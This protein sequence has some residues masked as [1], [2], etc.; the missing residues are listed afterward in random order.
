MDGFFWCVELA[1][2]DG[3][4]RRDRRSLAPPQVGTTAVRTPSRT[5]KTT[6]RQSNRPGKHAVDDN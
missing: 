4:I 2:R 5:A 1:E 6:A 3:R